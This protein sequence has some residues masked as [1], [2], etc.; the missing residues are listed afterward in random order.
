MILHLHD[1]VI[2]SVLTS[3]AFSGQ[4]RVGGERL[5]QCYIVGTSRPFS[6]YRSWSW[7]FL[8]EHFRE[9]EVEYRYLIVT[10][11]CASSPGLE[12]YLLQNV[13]AGWLSAVV[14]GAFECIF[15][16]ETKNL[17]YWSGVFGPL[18]FLHSLK[19]SLLMCENVT[20]VFRLYDKSFERGLNRWICC[21][22]LLHMVTDSLGTDCSGFRSPAAGKQTDSRSAQIILQP[23]ADKYIF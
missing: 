21:F 4:H 1:D 23:S 11:V 8:S 19:L 14:C 17:W 16:T 2:V 15:L 7:S 6:L 3:G 18:G 20:A 9:S 5:L 22:T 13:R 10:T 12:G